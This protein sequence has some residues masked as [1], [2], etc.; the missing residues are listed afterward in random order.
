MPI[1]TIVNIRMDKVYKMEEVVEKIIDSLETEKIRWLTLQF[2]DIRGFIKEVTIKRRGEREWIQRLFKKGVGKLDGSSVEGF[3]DI[4]DSDLTLIPDPTTYGVIPWMDKTVRFISNI[5]IRGVGY[6]KDPR[7]N[8]VR[9]LEKTGGYI[10]MMGAEVEFFIFRNVTSEVDNNRYRYSLTI[11]T[12]EAPIT[13]GIPYK[14]KGGYYIE[15][16][17]DTTSTFRAELIKVLEEMFTIEVE[18]HHHEVAIAGQSE[19]NIRYGDPVSTADNI[20]TLKYVARRLARDMGFTPVFMPKPIPVDNGSGLHIHMS[21]LKD[22]R[23]IFY[24]PD[25]EYAGLSQEARYFIGGLLEHGRALSALV[26]PTVNSY[27]R[28]V[29]GYEAP[30]YLVWGRGNRS[31]AVRVPYYQP[32]SRNVKI[33]YRPP[34][35]SCNPYIAFAAVLAA[36]LDGIRRKIEPGPPID[37][38]VYRMPP[39]KVSEL[40]IKTLPKNLGEALDELEADSRFLKGFISDDL[41]DSYI[42]LKRSEVKELAKYAS[43]AEYM[44]YLGL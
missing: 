38:N 12:D 10:P 44:M 9:A 23:N 24:D 40:G 13:D 27:R 8:L 4:S 15:G 20:V 3:Q 1:E 5:L 19:I 43:P 36:G 21:L 11:S 6:P 26:S 22:E 16:G 7:G 34:D 28:L 30:I 31:A 2:T 25:D 37:E 39:K 14:A 17:R 32:S 42:E 35:P 29:P 41:L 33:E 18:S